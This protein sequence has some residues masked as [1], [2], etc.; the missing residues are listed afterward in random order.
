MH[1]STVLCV[2]FL[3]HHLATGFPVPGSDHG[4][5]IEIGDA[6]TSLRAQFGW[7]N[8]T[9]PLCKTVFTAIDIALQ[10]GPKAG[11]GTGQ[12]GSG[13][14][15][16]GDAGSGLGHSGSGDDGSGTVHQ[17]ILA[18]AALGSPDLQL[19]FAVRPSAASVVAVM[20]G[21][22]SLELAAAPP[23]VALEAAVASL[24]LTLETAVASPFLALET[25]M[26]PPSLAL[27][28]A[29]VPLLP[30]L[31][32]AGLLPLALETDRIGSSFACLQEQLILPFFIFQAGLSSSGT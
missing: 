11:K 19:A 2:V 18:G 14:A 28:T 30:A 29:T 23:P 1:I 4:H 5:L 9:C 6:V 26:S 20:V 12:S 32:T 22:P 17:R 15:V 24:H 21:L 25:A 16:S 27:E 3:Q 7:R 31:E 8:L 10:V 13:D